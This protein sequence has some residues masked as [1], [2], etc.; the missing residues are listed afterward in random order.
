MKGLTTLC[1]LV[2]YLRHFP[3]LVGFPAIAFSKLSH[4]VWA[5]CSFVASPTLACPQGQSVW[6]T[7]LCDVSAKE[8]VTQAKLSSFSILL[9]VDQPRHLVVDDSIRKTLSTGP[10][11][12]TPPPFVF[13][14]KRAR[15]PPLTALGKNPRAFHSFLRF[16]KQYPGRM[17]IFVNIVGFCY[18]V[19]NL[20]TCFLALETSKLYI[21][22]WC[23]VSLASFIVLNPQGSSRW[24]TSQSSWAGK[25]SQ[26]RLTLLYST[27][28]S[29]DLPT[30]CPYG[31]CDGCR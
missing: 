1:V 29:I 11:G 4:L 10:W 12:V 25:W 17:F 15:L 13:A 21:I 18:S 5:W 9:H 20:I 27:Q 19:E 31:T 22:M 2:S 8:K 7:L 23:Y 14:R 24:S 30:K 16:P 3:L 26:A 6:I 28:G